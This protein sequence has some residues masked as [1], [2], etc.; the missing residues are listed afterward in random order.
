MLGEWEQ[1]PWLRPLGER[2]HPSSPLM[3]D[4]SPSWLAATA[5]GMDVLTR[6]KAKS[7]ASGEAPIHRRFCKSRRF[8]YD[9]A[10][11][12]VAAA[13]LVGR[14]QV[15]R[16]VAERVA[17]PRYAHPGTSGWGLNLKR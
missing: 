2:N 10:R 15:P 1:L 3:M 7:L 9:R 6:P 14:G 17:I 5:M 4:G 16:N 12:R 8:L 11:Q 13:L